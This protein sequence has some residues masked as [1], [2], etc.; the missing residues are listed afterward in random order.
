MQIKTRAEWGAVPPRRNARLRLPVGELWLHHAAGA[1][2]AGGNGFYDDD[3]RAI[4]RFH[5]HTRGWSDIAYN[6]LV[7]RTGTAWEGRGHSVI[8]GHTAGRN[9]ISQAICAIGNYEL[10]R[11]SPEMLEAIANLVAHGLLA[12]WWSTLITGPHREA[13]GA[14]TSCCGRYLIAEI[15]QINRR[16]QAIIAELSERPVPVA[17]PVTPDLNLLISQRIVSD[18]DCED[19]G[20]WSLLEDG[21]II[22]HGSAPYLGCVHEPDT[23]D[24]WG[25]RRAARLIR[26]GDGYV[27]MATTGE[28]YG[29]KF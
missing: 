4:Q 13:P 20:A 11:P 8:G 5:M 15:P 6:F 26:S 12:G 27:I 19:G 7:D 3:V 10:H 2:D 1:Q 21:G 18:L 24:H 28:T 29:P 23:R 25:N 22:T 16:T 9:S 17:E 14:S